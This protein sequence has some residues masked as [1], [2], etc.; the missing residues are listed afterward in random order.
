MRIPRLLVDLQTAVRRCGA[1]LLDARGTWVNLPEVRYLRA[2]LD[3]G[4]PVPRTVKA[5]TLAKADLLLVALKLTRCPPVATNIQWCPQTPWGRYWWLYSVEL[6]QE[7]SWCHPAFVDGFRYGGRIRIAES[8]EGLPRGNNPYV[9]AAEDAWDR[10]YILGLATPADLR[11]W[12][13]VLSCPAQA[14]ERERPEA[15]REAEQVVQVPILRLVAGG[16]R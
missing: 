13:L 11:S 6:V 5:A 10:G 1:G 14:F 15:E 7:I 3:I 12:L 16:G 4:R 8:V 9:D 2:A